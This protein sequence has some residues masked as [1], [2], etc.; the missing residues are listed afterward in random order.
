[1]FKFCEM[2]LKFAILEIFPYVKRCRL[3][4]WTNLNPLYTGMLFAK[5]GWNWPSGKFVALHW[6]NLY[7]LTPKMLCAKFGWNWPTGSGEG[8]FKNLS[9]YFRY[10][11]IT[12][13]LKIAIKSYSLEDK[14]ELVIQSRMLFQWNWTFD[15]KEESYYHHWPWMWSFFY[16]KKNWNSIHQRFCE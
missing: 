10:F 16:L 7:I 6:L 5:F 9:M 13:I 3:S 8:D 4:I 14:L 11:S 15:S 2:F 1:M 12:Q